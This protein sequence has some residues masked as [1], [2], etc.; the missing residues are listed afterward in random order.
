LTQKKAKEG[1][2]EPLF[3]ELVS[4]GELQLIRLY[5]VPHRLALNPYIIISNKSKKCE[6]LKARG[7]MKGSIVVAEGLDVLVLLPVGC[8][9]LQ[10]VISLCTQ[11]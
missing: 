6:K 8:I 1:E 2:A 3:A 7:T 4:A 10:E 11:R 9:L 5:L